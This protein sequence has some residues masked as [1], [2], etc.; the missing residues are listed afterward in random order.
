MK[1][2]SSGAC[3]RV[4]SDKVQ[5]SSSGKLIVTAYAELNELLEYLKFFDFFSLF[6]FECPVCLLNATAKPMR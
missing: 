6:Q 5:Y 3:A 1:G 4:R 2:A